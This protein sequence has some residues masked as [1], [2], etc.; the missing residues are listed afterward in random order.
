MMSIKGTNQ[1]KSN[2][3]QNNKIVIKH[4][5]EIGNKKVKEWAKN[6]YKILSGDNKDR[7]RNMRNY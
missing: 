4:A 5:K 2:I 1:L 7:L 6:C 3:Y